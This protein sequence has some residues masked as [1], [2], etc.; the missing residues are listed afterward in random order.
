MDGIQHIGLSASVG[1]NQGV[2]TRAELKLGLSII[3][4]LKQRET[5]EL[6]RVKLGGSRA[7]SLLLKK[8]Y[9]RHSP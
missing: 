3:P 4:E 7:E 1:T 8:G 2:N 6:H 5:I 9:T